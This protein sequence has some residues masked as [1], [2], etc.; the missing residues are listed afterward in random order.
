MIAAGFLRQAAL[1]SQWNSYCERA[2]ISARYGAK[3]SKRITVWQIVGSG[4]ASRQRA[5]LFFNS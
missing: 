3:A 2:R 5:G 4:N 1:Q